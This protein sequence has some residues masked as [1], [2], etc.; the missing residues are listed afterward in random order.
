MIVDDIIFSRMSQDFDILYN[1]IDEFASI[2]YRSYDLNTL[3]ALIGEI[4][5]I[6]SEKSDHEIYHIWMSSR[7]DIFPTKRRAAR[8]ILCDIRNSICNMIDST[9]NQ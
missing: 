1:D 2:I 7:A 5:C 9:Y 6:L 3:N 8:D 4:D